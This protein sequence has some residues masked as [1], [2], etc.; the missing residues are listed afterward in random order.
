MSDHNVTYKIDSTTDGIA[1]VTF[2]C[3]DT[4]IVHSRAVNVQDCADDEAIAVR[5]T[6]VANGVANKIAAKVIGA[7]L[8]S[9]EAEAPEGESSE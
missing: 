8:V 4:D 2:T 7:P 9:V 1:Q 6:Q 5:V 3:G